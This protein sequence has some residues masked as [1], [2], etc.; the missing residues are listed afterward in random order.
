MTAIEFDALPLHDATL[1]TLTIEWPRRSC[2]LVFTL[3]HQPG[4]SPSAGT[5]TFDGLREASLPL[6]EPWGRSNSVNAASCPEAGVFVIEL[7]SGD[8]LRFVATG[9]KWMSNRDDR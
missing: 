3:V 1:S 6:Q 5:L 7:Q 8:Q 2:T 4:Q 9:Y